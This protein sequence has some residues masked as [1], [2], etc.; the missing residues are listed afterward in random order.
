MNHSEEPLMIGCRHRI[1]LRMVFCVLASSLIFATAGCGATHSTLDSKNPVPPLSILLHPADTTVP[2]TRT[3]SFKVVAEGPGQLTYQWSKNGS[4]IPGAV[5][6]TY[7]TPPVTT[8]DSGSVFNVAV[9]AQGTSVS[10]HDAALKVGPR[11]PAEGDLR[12]QQVN[13]KS[14]DSMVGWGYLDIL[15]YPIGFWYPNTV[16]TP[17]RLGTGQCVEGIRYDCGWKYT[18]WHLNDG[19]P[20]NAGYIP[21]ALEELDLR[22]GNLSNVSVVT[23]LD[24]EAS[25]DVFAFSYLEGKTVVFDRRHEIVSLGELKTAIA[26]D[27]K[28]GRVV[29]AVSFNDATGNIHF[30][31]YGWAEDKGVYETN[32][33]TASFNDIGQAATSLANDGYIIT[34][35]GGNGKDGYIL[36]GTRLRGDSIPRPILVSPGGS[37]S[38]EGFALVG[39]AVNT[40]PNKWPDDPPVW[41]YER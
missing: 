4:P 30:L 1:P 36:V 25:E 7:T 19:G 34:A 10:S 12:F 26:E 20:I 23:S 2:L 41:I 22:L 8:A 38:H 14:V 39:W 16:G 33:L 35:F 28:N 6:A 3:A 32:V 21:A 27:G 11:S 17:L 24:I 13:A 9:S 18:I 29:T 31:S 40:L 37:T 5:G 15:W